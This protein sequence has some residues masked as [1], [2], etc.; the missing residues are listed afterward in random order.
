MTLA[1]GCFQSNSNMLH[2]GTG[3]ALEFAKLLRKILYVFDVER[4]IWLWY[5]LD[6]DLF[7]ACDQ[8]S[9]EQFAAPTFLSRTSI[10]GVRNIYDYP[11]ALLE[12]NNL[13]KRSLYLPC[14]E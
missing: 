5:H 10:V 2:G 7:Y 3:W 1:F 6:Q 14:R 4:N 13:F 11:D 8:M 9:E 12:L